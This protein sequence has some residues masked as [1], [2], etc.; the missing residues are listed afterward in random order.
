MTIVVAM[1]TMSMMQ[2]ISAADAAAADFQGVDG[3]TAL[4]VAFA[5]DNTDCVRLLLSAG[6]QLVVTDR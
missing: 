4:H 6:A 1:M 3:E 5:C 2:M